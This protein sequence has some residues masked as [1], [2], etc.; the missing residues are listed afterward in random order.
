MNSLIF[1]KNYLIHSYKFYKAGW[2]RLFLKHHEPFRK[3][4]RK[5]FKFILFTV[6]L[7]VFFSL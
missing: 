7:I 5:V 1:F 4:C 6:K 3:K 2:P